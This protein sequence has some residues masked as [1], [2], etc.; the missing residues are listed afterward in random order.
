MM[1]FSSAPVRLLF[2]ALL[3]TTMAIAGPLRAQEETPES[4][5]NA[6][7][8]VKTEVPGNA[9]TAEFLGTEREGSGVVIDDKGLVL[10]IG[11]LILEAMSAT[12]SDGKGRSVP[13]EIVAYD[14]DTGFGLLRA[15]EPLGIKPIRLGSSDAVAESDPVLAVG[16]DDG[17]VVVPSYVTSRTQFAGYWEYLLDSAIYVAPPHPQWAGAALIDHS[18]KLV[19]IGSLLVANAAPNRPTTG[20]LPGSMF[21]PVDLLKPIMSDLLTEGRSSASARPWLGMFTR[22][23]RDGVTIL[24]VV[25]EGPAA[26]AG[27]AAGD[28]VLRVGDEDVHDMAQMFRSIW[29]RGAAGIDVPLTIRRAEED[30]EVSVH[31]RDRYT[32]LRLDPTY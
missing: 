20:D 21:V 4:I 16:Y 19:G 1:L 3:A 31:S 26:Q 9:R 30:R 5:L 18:G 11:Y 22:D 25:P 23:T 28:V 32:Y 29:A 2:V 13:A 24:N 6:V 27:L 17:L 10:T 7:V 8:S 14:Y 15:I 12:V